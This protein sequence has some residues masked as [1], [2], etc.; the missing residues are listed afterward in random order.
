MMRASLTGTPA[1]PVPAVARLDDG[2]VRVHAA[3]R[4]GEETTE[5]DD[6]ARGARRRRRRREELD[7]TDGCG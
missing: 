3:T 6:G 2:V 4:V 7:G 1:A 5:T